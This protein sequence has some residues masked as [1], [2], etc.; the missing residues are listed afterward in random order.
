[1]VKAILDGRKTQ[2]RRVMKPQPY[3]AKTGSWFW[4]HGDNQHVWSES[5]FPHIRHDCPF[6]IEGDKLWVRET[7]RTVHDPGTCLEGA[8]EIDYAADGRDRIMDRI[9]KGNW[10]P[11][12]HMPRW[13][14]RI[15][16]EITEVRVQRVQEISEEDA[17]AEGVK[18]HV[19]AKWWQGYHKDDP[20][21]HQCAPADIN[22]DPPDW[23]IE[24]KPYRDL[25]HLNKDAKQMFR[26]LWDSINEKR[27]F[28][29]DKNPWTWAIAFKRIKP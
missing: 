24:A 7:F 10:K 3:Q 28:G 18:P 8:L 12:I 29:W 4:S 6:G 16:L 11:S 9:G 17:K 19:E 1:M 22:G 14:S 23:L 20:L 13:A 25:S 2:T 5:P 27:G 26:F 15:T 21:L